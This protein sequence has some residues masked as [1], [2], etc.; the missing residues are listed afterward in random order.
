MVSIP[1]SVLGVLFICRLFAPL[2][3][4]AILICWATEVRCQDSSFDCSNS[5]KPAEVAICSDASLSRLDRQLNQLY[6]SHLSAGPTALVVTFSDFSFTSSNGWVAFWYRGEI[7]GYTGD[8]HSVRTSN[9]GVVFNPADVVEY[10]TY[11]EPKSQFLNVAP[12]CAGRQSCALTQGG[13]G[14]IGFCPDG[15]QPKIINALKDLMRF[16]SPTGAR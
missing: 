5:T 14:A 9:G 12:F 2:A 8:H 4:V 15:A 3:V 6:S 13:G 11:S 7:D 16:Y 10:D 1:S